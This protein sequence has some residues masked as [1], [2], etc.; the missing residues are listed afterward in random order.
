LALLDSD[1]FSGYGTLLS[2]RFAVDDKPQLSVT[3]TGPLGLGAYLGSAAS[4]Q[5]QV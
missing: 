1:V 3:N 4:A 2:F 5:G